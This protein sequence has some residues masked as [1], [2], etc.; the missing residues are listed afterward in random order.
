MMRFALLV[1]AVL[2]AEAVADVSITKDEVK[3]KGF[4][5]IFFPSNIN[6]FPSG[7]VQLQG[8]LQQDVYQPPKRCQREV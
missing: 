2:V 7:Y 3:K 1:L 6:R 5:S 8:T 4:K